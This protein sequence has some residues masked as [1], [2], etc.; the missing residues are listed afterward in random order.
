[1]QKI[2]VTAHFD[3]KAYDI[4]CQLAEDEGVDMGEAISRALGLKKLLLDTVRGGG[5]ML[6]QNNETVVEI[7]G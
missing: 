7:K 5:K 6:I 1:M 4:L 2:S 3:P